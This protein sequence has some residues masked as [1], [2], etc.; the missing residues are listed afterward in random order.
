VCGV[1]KSNQ[2]AV[3]CVVGR[4]LAEEKKDE[5][6]AEVES[7]FGTSDVVADAEKEESHPEEK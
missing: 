5:G 6:T 7:P 4:L 2:L 1:V 3:E